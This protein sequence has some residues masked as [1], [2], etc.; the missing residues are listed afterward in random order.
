MTRG[1]RGAKNLVFPD[2]LPLH[3]L[4][5]RACERELEGS[6]RAGRVG[7]TLTGNTEGSTVVGAGTV[8]G[9]AKRDIHR[10][11]EIE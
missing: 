4:C 6:Y 7:D 11:I 3:Q 1:K 8:A 10:I 5:A 9:E 2:N